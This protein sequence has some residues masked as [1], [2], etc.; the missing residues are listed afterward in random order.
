M[1]AIAI[2]TSHSTYGRV[3]CRIIRRVGDG[4]DTGTEPDALPMSGTITFTPLTKWDRTTDYSALASN[5]AITGQLNPL[6]GE[7]MSPGQPPTIGVDLL[8]GVYSVSFALDHGTFA[9]FNVEVKA[10]HTA[11]A[12][13]DLAHEVPYSPPPGV[14]T[15]M[16]VP[17][18]ITDGYLLSVSGGALVGVDPATL[19]GGSEV[20]QVTL[21]EDL[22]YTLPAGVAPNRVHSVVFTQDATGGHTVTYGGAPVTVDTT[23]GASTL[24]EV[25]P[26]GTLV[27]PGASAPASTVDWSDVTDKPATYAP[28]AHKASHATGGTDALTPADIGAAP[29][30]GADDNYVTDAEKVKLANLSGANSGDQDL[31][32]YLAMSAAPEL[33]R[34]TMSAALVAGANVT[35]TPN[36]AGDSITIAAESGGASTPSGGVTP[37]RILRGGWADFASGVSVQV[38]Q[39]W[40]G[41]PVVVDRALSV[42]SFIT[43]I[44]TAAVTPG[45]TATAAIYSRTGPDSG[46]L[47]HTLGSFAIDSTGTKTVAVSGVT[48]QPGEYWIVSLNTE[49]YTVVGVRGFYFAGMGSNHL[50]GLVG[51]NLWLG[52]HYGPTALDETVTGLLPR[53]DDNLSKIGVP[54]FITAAA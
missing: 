35:I 5:E 9:S 40:T 48:L 37:A 17:S 38:G 47:L 6:T 34:D 29:A 41:T 46:T 1:T 28:T 20:E 3:V 13:L 22:A 10:S 49:N 27:Y 32:G 18:G 7:M 44:S 24:V 43:Q 52:W 23:A 50:R 8:V 2:P 42:G 51:N 26:G 11:V 45:A 30:L 19:G 21:T 36:D 39:R 54:H 16:L 14:Q 12:P 53:L 25:W 4:D 33:I 31:S 15:T